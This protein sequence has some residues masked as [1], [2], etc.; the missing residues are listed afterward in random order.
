[1]TD[2]DIPPKSKIRPRRVN[3]DTQFM[4]RFS[5][6]EKERLEADA[7]SE[8]YDNASDYVRDR[9]FKTPSGGDVRDQQRVDGELFTDKQKCEL[10]VAVIHQYRIHER[11]FEQ[12][13]GKE[14][15]DDERRQIIDELGLGR[16]LGSGA[17]GA[18]AE[19]H[20]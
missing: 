9:L 16:L 20:S 5:T 6:S 13:G 15:F 3:R 14:G 7:R 19:V 12:A 11:A 17:Q 2:K 10:A 4:I 8:G 18:E 1:M